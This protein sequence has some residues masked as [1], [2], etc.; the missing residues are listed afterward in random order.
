MS[1]SPS[2]DEGVEFLNEWLY[3]TRRRARQSEEE[4]SDGQGGKG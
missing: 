4:F 3:I 1:V 2:V